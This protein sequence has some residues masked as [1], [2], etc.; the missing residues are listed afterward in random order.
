MLSANATTSAAACHRACAENVVRTA[1]LEREQ[2]TPLW[3]LLLRHLIIGNSANSDTVR[4]ALAELPQCFVPIAEF[5]THLEH[6]RFSIGLARADCNQWRSGRAS[7]IVF[8]LSSYSQRN[9]QE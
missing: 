7:E 6:S 8:P 5:R 9:V 3:G 1:L 2:P 4:S